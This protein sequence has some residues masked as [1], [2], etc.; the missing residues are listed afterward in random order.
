MA[1]IFC[2]EC[3]KQ[4]SSH[5]VNCPNCGFPINNINSPKIVVKQKEGCF[6]QTLNLG[7]LIVLFIGVMML[8][9][10]VMLSVNDWKKTK[11]K[12]QTKTEKSIK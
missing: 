7:C 5:S 2:P 8:I 9:G 11:I 6:L 10:V 1:L 4:I 12:N 3:K